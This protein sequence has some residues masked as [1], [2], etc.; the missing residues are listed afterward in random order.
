MLSTSGGGPPSFLYNGKFLS[1][2]ELNLAPYVF[3]HSILLEQRS[4]FC[5]LILFLWRMKGKLISCSQSFNVK[6]LNC[7]APNYAH[8]LS[9]RIRQQSTYF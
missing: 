3:H 8:F 4:N 7:F 1:A 5:I 2:L 9:D 6:Y